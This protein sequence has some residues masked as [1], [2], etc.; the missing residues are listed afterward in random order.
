MYYTN[1]CMHVV[2]STVE[3]LYI[4]AMEKKISQSQPPHCQSLSLLLLQLAGAPLTLTCDYTLSLSVDTTVETAV[5]WMV[6]GSV[7]DTSQDGW[8]STD[9]DTITFSHMTTSD[10]DSY[11]CTLTITAPQTRHVIAQGPVQSAEEIKVIHNTCIN[12]C[13]CF[14]CILYMYVHIK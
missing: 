6:N 8:I 14:L 9:G 1:A 7:V 5:S 2:H 10:S 3:L 4:S 11:T 12:S 13:V